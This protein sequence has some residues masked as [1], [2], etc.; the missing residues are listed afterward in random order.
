MNFHLA[1]RGFLFAAAIL[2]AFSNLPLAGPSDIEISK[3]MRSCLKENE[4]FS[5]E[6]IGLSNT[7]LISI[8]KFETGSGTSYTVQDSIMLKANEANSSDIAILN[9]TAEIE[10]VLRDRYAEMNLTFD[11]LYPTSFE[12]GEILAMM[13]R[14]NDSRQPN[15]GK[16]KLWIG[17]DTPEFDC[18]DRES[19]FRA[20]HT[21]LSNPVASGVGWPFVDAVWE[22]MNYTRNMDSN[23]SAALKDMEDIEGTS[24]NTEAL[25]NHLELSLENVQNASNTIS[26]SA[27]FD[28]WRYSFCWPIKYNKTSVITAK[29]L[30]KRLHERMDVVFTIPKKAKSMSL[31]GLE[32]I[33][34]CGSNR[35]K[36]LRPK[37]RVTFWAKMSEEERDF[38]M[39]LSSEVSPGPLFPAYA[40]NRWMG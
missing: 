20:C 39:L 27:L 3:F 13:M 11:S 4:S 25:L 17:T 1:A 7:Y 22:F 23:F 35:E 28:P 36:A 5:K 21:P 18:N 38:L 30:V 2:L 40:R 37:A 16:C 26:Q 32:R 15:E 9:N 31:A 8:G 6:R 24:E 19:C 12:I 29:I 34:L 14:F 10:G 33:E